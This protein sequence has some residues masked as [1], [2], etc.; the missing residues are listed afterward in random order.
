[1]PAGPP[2]GAR[3][4]SAGDLEAAAAGRAAEQSGSSGAWTGL[5][6][7]I[8][9]NLHL[10]FASAVLASGKPVASA[11]EWRKAGA[12]LPRGAPGTWLI[13]GTG[14]MRRAVRAFAPGEVSWPPGRRPGPG[15]VPRLPGPGMDVTGALVSTARI[16]GWDAVRAGQPGPV[17]VNWRARSLAV[18]GDGDRA[19]L[20][21]ARLAHVLFHVVS[22]DAPPGPGAASCCFGAGEA[23][24]DSAA[25]LVLR[26]LGADPG[27]A[28]IVIPAPRD[29]AGTPGALAAACETAAGAAAQ[30]TR[31]ASKILA[32]LPP[33]A[34]ARRRGAGRQRPAVRPDLE[35]APFPVPPPPGR[36][37]RHPEP[38]GT[39]PTMPRPARP[40]V[41]ERPAPD[42]EIVRVNEAAAGFFASQ[43]L[44]GS[45]AERYLAEER[46]LGPELRREWGFGYAPGKWTGLLNHLRRNG[47]GER[48]ALAAG[49][50]RRSDRGSLYDVF[51]DRV[52][53]PVKDSEGR[54]AGFAGRA[55]PGSGNDVPKYLNTQE[56]QAYAKDH[57]LFG[58]HEAR[59]AL[60]AG[61]RPVLVEGYFD[62]IAVTASGG[63]RFA[64]VAPGGTNL[65]D[66]QLAA[67]AKA[68]DLEQAPLLVA[69][70]P[71]T[72]GM[73]AA[74]RDYARILPWCPVRRAVI[75]E[76]DPAGIFE[77]D[78]P[79]GL[80]R[81]LAEGERPL[82]DIVTDL[83][84]DKHDRRRRHPEEAAE[85]PW[86]TSFDSIES[87][88]AGI[89][90]AARMLAR[91]W[92]RDLTH[93]QLARIALRTGASWSFVHW[94]AHLE[95]LP[96]VPEKA[97]RSWSRLLA[98]ARLP[99]PPDCPAVLSAVDWDPPERPG[100]EPSR[101]QLQAMAVFDE[102]APAARPPPGNARQPGPPAAAPPVSG[103]VLQA[104]RRPR[105]SPRG[106]GVPGKAG[107]VPH[108]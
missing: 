38:P 88:L 53:L 16:L 93:R 59:K 10:G 22:G 70:D 77:R 83:A 47:F 46:K 18:P 106:G 39:G 104:V 54:I 100:W 30:V 64:G 7:E 81:A 69:R 56:T 63:G 73:K 66:E 13:A 31:H 79:G 65:G 107:P 3:R 23:I 55:L 6:D 25:W 43:L 96:T 67:L 36:P 52:M 60:A 35:A 19:G 92:P 20:P 78:G 12:R 98:R 44:P 58:L 94:A 91:D 27:A 17:R 40:E 99:S 2:S 21:A 74:G 5:L 29:W 85:F 57:L 76:E 103:P 26:R 41:R 50:V 61:A 108:R 72:A 33:P 90:E 11:E 71:D 80:A 24:A 49:L 86:I 15:P 48:A 68:C 95:V 34:P 28:G 62:V 97:R 37:S 51:R 45:P 105:G 89:R 102:N 8:A 42:P 9:V 82:A 84:L 75:L 32:P 87:Q 101:P 14:T 4:P 1:M